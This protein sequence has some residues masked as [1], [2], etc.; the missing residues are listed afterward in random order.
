MEVPKNKSGYGRSVITELV[1]YELGGAARL[2]FSPEGVRCRLD[3][4]GKWLAPVMNKSRG[5]SIT[6]NAGA[7]AENN[8]PC[9]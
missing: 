8:N 6:K 2:L 7:P 1:P 5:G 9:A 3:T 4:P